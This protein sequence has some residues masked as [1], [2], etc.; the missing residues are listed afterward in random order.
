MKKGIGPQVGPDRLLPPGEK[1]KGTGPPADAD[2]KRKG[3]GPPADEKR[4]GTGPPAN[5]NET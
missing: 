2:E 1:R 5:E 4:K 3:T